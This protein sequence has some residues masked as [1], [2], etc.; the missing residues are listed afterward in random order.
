MTIEEKDFGAVDGSL[1]FLLILSMYL[2]IYFIYIFIYR[3]CTEVVE[4]NKSHLCEF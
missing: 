4:A 3:W 1:S 2:F